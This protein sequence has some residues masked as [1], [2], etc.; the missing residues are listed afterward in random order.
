[1]NLTR[2]DIGLRHHFL[3]LRFGLGQLRLYFLGIGQTL[4]DL[5]TPHVQHLEDWSIGEPVKD[6][7]HDAEADD[8]GEQLRPVYTEGRGNPLDVCYRCLRRC[9]RHQE[10][11]I[12]NRTLALQELGCPC[13]L[14]ERSCSRT[15][16]VLRPISLHQ[17]QGVEHDRLSEG[18]G[19]NR[20]DQNLRRGAGITSH[21]IRSCHADQAN[22]QRPRQSLPNQRVCCQSYRFVL[23]FSA[24]T[25]VEYVQAAEKSSSVCGSQ[26]LLPHAGHISRVKTAHN[27]MKTSACTKPT[28]NSMK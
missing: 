28:S 21:G 9:L 18:D 14:A 27:N 12:H 16:L 7:A 24:A 6:D 10:K 19:Q 11:N 22:R 20:L 3:A 25:A 8:L 26:I 5:L 17:E 4:S 1:M 15:P 23:P 13:R 2:L